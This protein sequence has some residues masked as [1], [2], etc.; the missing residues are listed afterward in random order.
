MTTTATEGFDARA[1]LP[2]KLYRAVTD[3]LPPGGRGDVGR[4]LPGQPG[5][6]PLAR[7]AYLWL[8]LWPSIAIR[9]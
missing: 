8:Y 7:K 9:V 1:Y 2:R 4:H 3:I 6:G 5:H